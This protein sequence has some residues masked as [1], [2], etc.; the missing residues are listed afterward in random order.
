MPNASAKIKP[1]SL[2][3]GALLGALSALTLIGL[4]SLGD[5]LFGYP[6]VPF[7]IFDW[8]A[9][10]LPGALI[11]FV[12]S[13]MVAVIRFFQSF[14]PIGDI[15][16]A[17]KLAEQTIAVVQLIIGGALFGA[18]LAW[19][20]QKPSRN[21]TLYGI[22]GGLVLLASTILIE[23]NLGNVNAIGVAALW[24]AF[25][26]IGWGWG[27]ALLIQRAGV[28]VF[29]EERAAKQNL[30]RRQFITVSGAGLTAAALGAWGIGRIFGDNTLDGQTGAPAPAMSADDPFGASLTSGPAAS[31]SA[32]ELAARPAPV[33]GTRPELTANEDFY[34]IDI[35]TRPPEIDE[36]GWSLRVSG[37]VDEQMQ[38]GMEDLRAMP[39]QTQIL[40]MQCISNPVGG[41]LTSSSR[42]TGVLL[43]DV[44]ARAGIQ[45]AATGALFKSVDGFF[46]FV[47]MED[48][49][50]DRCMLVYDMNG[51]PLPIEHGFPLRVYIPNRY[52]MKQPKWIES[53]ELMSERVDGYWVVRGWDKEARPQTVSV[54]D[55]VMVDPDGGTAHSGGIAW[56]GD[57]GISAVQVNVDDGGWEE[58]ELITPALSPLT[59]VLWRF[60]FPYES[61]RHTL[62]VRALD[63]NGEIQTAEVAPTA[64]SGA[65]GIH[66]VTV[67][68]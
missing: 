35:N 32:D 27:L 65:T 36:T 38:F 49:M 24:L 63:G 57:R 62:S 48:I 64:P 13:S 12:I 30:S 3:Q 40:T 50:D 31:P 15:S 60:T 10:T 43:K 39:S 28:S 25:L 58:A 67:N 61:G 9:R 2:W 18:L 41:D 37:L 33:Q 51:E 14:L 52:G 5:R 23:N 11:G 26:F 44:L 54:V 17:A 8:M 66:S 22:V 1:S 55:T 19:L 29:E 16:T 46:E 20:A 21:V 4:L 7:D 56:A 59:W 53:I 34:R 6:F 47:T 45:A 68:L 42:W